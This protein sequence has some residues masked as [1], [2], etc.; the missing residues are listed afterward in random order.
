MIRISLVSLILLLNIS[1][2]Q[3]QLSNNTSISGEIVN[4]SKSEIYLFQLGGNEL[5]PLDTFLF[6]ASNTGATQTFSFDFN[7]EKPDFYQ[8]SFGEKQ[9]SIVILSPNDHMKIS[10]D[11]NNMRKIKSVSGSTETENLF[12]I[13]TDTDKF[14]VKKADLEEQYRKVYGT[15]E[16]DSVGAVLGKEFENVEAQR[17]VYLKQEM[18]KQNSLAG[19]VYL[20][21]IKMEK[22]LDFYGKYTPIMLKKYPD[23][24]YVK[25]LY[26]QYV[27]EKSKVNIAPGVMAP[28]I[29]LPTPEG[30][31]FKL[32]SLRGKV[33]LIDFWASWCGPC[34]R[35]NPHVVKLYEKY[36]DK[37]FDI[38]GVSL[39]KDKA[40]WVKAIAS[41]GLVWPQVSDLKY[42]QSE[43]GR[44]YGVGS[45]PH[46]VL[47]DKEGKII[48][49]GLRGATLDAKL[50]EIFGF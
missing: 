25:S 42:W 6:N 12:K 30:A 39:D 16:Q 3:A 20:D 41:D 36:H 28:E 5:I 48:A 17:I 19:L 26:N 23:N 38:L 40:K 14:E 22:N 21:A 33:V 34:R 13:A 15:P 10:L 27:S 9:F 8:V 50:K 1:F 29:D 4:N 46:T 45:I 7:V 35:A 37:G 49:I 32:S 43:A 11:A 31:N 47:I 18:L 24:L 44:A 2:S